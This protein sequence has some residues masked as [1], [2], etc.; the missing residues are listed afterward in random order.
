LL[1][2]S[3]VK[4]T[5]MSSSASWISVTTKVTH[6]IILSSLVTLNGWQLLE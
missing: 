3:P 2:P 6:H 5:F 4:P 1:I